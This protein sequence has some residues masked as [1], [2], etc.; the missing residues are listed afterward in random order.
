MTSQGAS[1]DASPPSGSASRTVLIAEDDAA[2][3]QIIETLLKRLGIAYISVH[4]GQQAFDVFAEGSK[5]SLILMD[6]DMPVLDG[7]TST[8]LIRDMDTAM[9]RPRT[10]IIG[11]SA[12]AFAED[13]ERCTASGMDDFIAKPFNVDEFT[14]L[15]DKWLAR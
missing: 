6:L 1:D 14:A 4:N 10:P 7:P 15:V 8:E 11:V 3:R 13:R 2:N 9:G 12:H 5:L